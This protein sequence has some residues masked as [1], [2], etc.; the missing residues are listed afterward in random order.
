MSDGQIKDV[1][2]VYRKILKASRSGKGVRLSWH[3][4][5]AIACDGAVQQCVETAEYEEEEANE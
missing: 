5:T 2:K 1:V 3:E 4:V